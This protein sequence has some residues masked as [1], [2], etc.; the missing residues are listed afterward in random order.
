[1]GDVC[2]AAAT[3]NALVCQKMEKTR[4]KKTKKRNIKNQ[5]KN[6]KKVVEGGY[7]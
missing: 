1:M 3:F 2:T 5:K 4:K 7:K 6:E